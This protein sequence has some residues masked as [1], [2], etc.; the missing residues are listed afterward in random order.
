MVKLGHRRLYPLIACGISLFVRPFV[1]HK[2]VTTV[3]R[4]Q[5]MPSRDLSRT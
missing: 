2:P 3:N 1:P 4:L 5:A